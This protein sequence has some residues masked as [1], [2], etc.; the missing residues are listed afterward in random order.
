MRKFLVHLV[1]LA[2]GLGIGR[3]SPASAADP[4]TGPIPP[5]IRVQKPVPGAGATGCFQ[6]CIPEKLAGKLL[7][8]RTVRD[9]S[10]TCKDL[11]EGELRDRFSA[12]GKLAQY[13]A[14][15]ET[16]MTDADVLEIRKASGPYFLMLTTFVWE[17]RNVFPDRLLR[18]LEIRH[19][20]PTM[21]E[22]GY[23]AKTMIPPGESGTFVMFDL[24]EMLPQL[25]GTIKVA[26]LTYCD[27]K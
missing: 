13:E 23:S 2:A 4:E 19:F 8:D 10:R 9:T 24:S 1:L 16:V 27:V 12:A 17:I 21:M 20:T 3:V 5:V 14:C 7:D 15:A 11:C 25:K 22:V 6:Q 18:T 26:R